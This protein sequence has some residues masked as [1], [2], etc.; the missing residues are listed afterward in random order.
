MRTGVHNT[1]NYMHNVKF[2]YT[3]DFDVERV[4]DFL[5]E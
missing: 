5:G 3:T 1:F 2:V 4:N